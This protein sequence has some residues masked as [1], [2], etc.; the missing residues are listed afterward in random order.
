MQEQRAR[1]TVM[2]GIGDADIEDG[3]GLVGQVGPHAKGREQALAGIGD[4]GGA[5]IEPGV[6]E[7]AERYPVDQSSREASLAGGERQQA[8]VQAGAHD[9]EIEPVALHRP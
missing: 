4:G 1:P 9:G 3:F 7:R 6:G 8:A 2:A 5:T